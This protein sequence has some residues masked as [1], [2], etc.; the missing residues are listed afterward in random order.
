MFLREVSLV[1][2]QKFFS[3]KERKEMMNKMVVQQ[4]KMTT[5][6]KTKLLKLKK[7]M[8]MVRVYKMIK[9]KCLSFKFMNCFLK[10]LYR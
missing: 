5:L 4:L 8:M 7:Q 6:N 9:S 2:V 3:K 1:T 10:I